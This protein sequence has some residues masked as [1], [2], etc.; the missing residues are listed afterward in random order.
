VTAIEG[1]HA[2]LGIDT[3]RFRL[4][5]FLAELAGTGELEVFDEP[6]EFIASLDALRNQARPEPETVPEPPAHKFPAQETTAGF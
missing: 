2:R 3:D 1:A 4:R 5:R 6:I